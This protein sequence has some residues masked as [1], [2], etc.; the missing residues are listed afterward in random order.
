MY[1]NKE[2]ELTP[3]PF[4]WDGLHL[5]PKFEKIGKG[6]GLTWSR[7]L[8]GVAGKEGW[9]F[10]GVVADK[11]DIFN[12]KKGLSTKMFLS[13]ITTNLHWNTWQKERNIYFAEIDVVRDKCITKQISNNL[14]IVL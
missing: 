8:E 4:C 13:A 10:W 11:S 6:G 9:T 5:L 3:P 12:D 1:G 14:I 7:F 2:K